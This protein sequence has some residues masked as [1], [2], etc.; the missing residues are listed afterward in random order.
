[1]KVNL[2]M[3][4]GAV[5]LVVIGGLSVGAVA[6]FAMGRAQ[7]NLSPI[8]SHRSFNEEMLQQMPTILSLDFTQQEKLRRV[9]YRTHKQLVSI[10]EDTRQ[11][12]RAVMDS[13]IAEISQMLT[14]EQ[15]RK[16]TDLEKARAD[17]RRAQ[18][19]FQGALN[20]AGNQPL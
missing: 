2:T 1:M 7:A 20:T 5:V 15:Q 17:M 10:R 6:G 19:K 3:V 14:A 13:A 16:L 8:H 4:I 9:S 18:D 11:R 12:N